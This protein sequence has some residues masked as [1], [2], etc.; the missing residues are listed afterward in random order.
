M[1]PRRLENLVSKY[2]DSADHVLN[3]LARSK[4]AQDISPENV[5]HVIDSAKSY[6]EDAKYYR[7][8]ERLETSLTSVSYTEGLLDA[9]RL[10]GAVDFQW[11]TPQVGEEKKTVL[12]SGV[13]DL[14]HVGHVRFLEEAKKA[15]GTNSELIVIIA[16]D[17]TV[18]KRKGKKPIV[19]EAQRCALVGALR[20]VDTAI[21]GFKRFDIGKV[22]DKIKPDIIAFG[23]DQG[24]MEKA[25]REHIQENKLKTKIVRVAKFG[26]HELA[27]SSIKQK[28]IENFV[29]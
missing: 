27:S 13:F 18:E 16:R 29:R 6:L 8:K 2:I 10:L 15:G 1:S 23:Y 3:H 26:R 5:N 19:S 17:S 9:L 21:L 20:V 22:V 25:I 11:P 4:V 24:D 7:E 14:L 28:I 12:A